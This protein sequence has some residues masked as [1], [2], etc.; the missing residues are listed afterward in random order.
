[1]PSGTPNAPSRPPGPSAPVPPNTPPPAIPPPPLTGQ[2]S[3]SFSTQIATGHAQTFGEQVTPPGFSTQVMSQGFTFERIVVNAY[4]FPR[5]S[6]TL[7]QY[8][9]NTNDVQNATRWNYA[10]LS[11]MDGTHTGVPKD[12]N[13]WMDIV[14]KICLALKT[15]SALRYIEIWNEPDG[16]LFLT[17]ANSPYTSNIAAYLDIYY[18]TVKA[19][20]ASGLVVKIGGPAGTGPTNTLHTVDAMLGNA[21]IS[22]DIDF[23]SYHHYDGDSGADVLSVALYA[24]LAAQHGRPGLPVYVTEWNFSFTKWVDATGVTDAIS[25]V[26]RRLTAFLTSGAAGACI[27]NLAAPANALNEQ[28]GE[29]GLFYNQSFTPKVQTFRLMSLILGLGAGDSQVVQSNFTGITS[30]LAALNNASQPVLVLTN[31]GSGPAN[32]TISLTGLPPNT[33]YAVAV[34]EASATNPTNAMRASF[35][36]ST[37]SSGGLGSLPCITLGRKSVVGLLFVPAPHPP[38]PTQAR[39]LPPP[40]TASPRL[41][42]FPSG[43]PPQQPPALPPSPPP[44]PDCCWWWCHLPTSRPPPSPVPSPPPQPPPGSPTITPSSQQQP[45]VPVRQHQLQP[46]SPTSAQL[47]PTSPTTAQLQPTSPTTAQLQPTSPTTAQLQPTSPTTAQLQPTS[48]TTA[49]L[50]PTLPTAGAPQSSSTTQ[51]RSA[52]ESSPSTSP[53]S[54]AQSRSTTQ[55]WS[56]TESQSSGPHTHSSA[57]GATGV[58]SLS[59][60]P[61]GV[62]RSKR[63]SKARTVVILGSVPTATSTSSSPGQPSLTTSLLSACSSTLGHSSVCLAS[64]PLPSIS[65]PTFPSNPILSSV[66][67]GAQPHRPIRAFS[68]IP[69]CRDSSF[70]RSRPGVSHINLPRPI[71]LRRRSNAESSYA[72]QLR[73]CLA[74]IEPAVTVA[75]DTAKGCTDPTTTPSICHLSLTARPYD[76]RPVASSPVTASLDLPDSANA[77]SIL[78]Q[79]LT[80][81]PSRIG[82]SYPVCSCFPSSFP[83]CGSQPSI[84]PSHPITGSQPSIDPSHPNSGSQP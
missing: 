15:H 6:I 73:R 70:A 82:F 30:S 29:A 80:S 12:W 17:I 45:P 24:A 18:Y 44:T 27:F 79:L 72:Q 67:S 59:T 2:I 19:I 20:R 39:T 8:I 28:D 21:S 81:C 61:A 76:H 84:T 3:A 34:W 77:K 14:Q 62:A 35:P 48:P 52:A 55:P 83:I 7:Q 57:T 10:Q 54:A 22:S 40:P 9:N 33:T 56:A 36:A 74:C 49:Q 43:L 16:N 65:Q 13:V 31:E 71:S 41:G 63:V 69:G 46:T 1:M 37:N 50:Q 38:P 58:A 32:L 5:S 4:A 26:G 42:S 60:S 78:A 23:V 66:A 11:K 68:H 75:P 47:Q 51:P 64:L 25:Y 53:W